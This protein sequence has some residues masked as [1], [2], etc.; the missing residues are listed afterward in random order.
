MS[1]LRATGGGFGRHELG[2]RAAALTYYAVLSLFPAL[3]ALVSILGL[4]GQGGSA[5]GSLLSQLERQGI[6]P[7]DAGGGVQGALSVL[8]EQTPT[9][10]LG[11]VVGLLAA[12]W[13]ASNYVKGFARAMNAIA[14]VPE[15]RPVWKLN[16]QLL[17]LTAGLLVLQAVAVVLV[18]VSGPL[19]ETVGALL[20]V[21]DAPLAAWN[22]AKL[23]ALAVVVVVVVA[24]L[25]HVTPS[26][27]PPR[28]RLASVGAVAAIALAAAA[29][30]LF[31]V[32]VALVAGSS[33]GRTYGTLAGVILFLFWLWIMNVALLLGAEL[34][35]Q[36][37]KASA[38]TPTSSSDPRPRP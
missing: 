19:V 6:I 24:L 12:L 30:L 38:A 9:P 35:A 32:Y 27:R 4:M 1:T 29:S 10:G 18:A 11:L 26:E 37:A 14:D 25:Y 28:L 16:L 3:I 8:L 2:D 22:A 5:I 21:G 15:R 13:S 31:G 34:D 23:P 36:L 20:H 17:A 7:T 33:Y